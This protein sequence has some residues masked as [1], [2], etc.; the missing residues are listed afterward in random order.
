[1]K[2]DVDNYD[3][4]IVISEV[5]SGAYLETEEGNRVGF[6]FRDDTVE[7]H[8]LPKDGGNRWFRINM[9]DLTVEAME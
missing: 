6:C 4:G 7:F 1:M 8:V 5:F 3:G 9:Q 2:L